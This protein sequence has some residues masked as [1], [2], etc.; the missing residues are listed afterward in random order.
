MDFVFGLVVD[1]GFYFFCGAFLAILFIVGVNILIFIFLV[2]GFRKQAKELEDLL[3][4]F[5]W[6]LRLGGSM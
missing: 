3:D 4:K 1:I 5:A 6:P 2:F